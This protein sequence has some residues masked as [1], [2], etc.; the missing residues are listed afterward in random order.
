MTKINNAIRRQHR[1]IAPLIFTFLIWTIISADSVQAQDWGFDPVIKIGGEVDD[2]ALL[3]IRT[4]EELKLEGY[5]VEA[6]VGIDY[7]SPL[8]SFSVTPRVLLRRY[9]DFD[10]SGATADNPD[11][12]DFESTDAFV[13]SLFR[14][15]MRSSSIGFRG[16]YQRQQVRTAERADTDLLIDDPD[17]ISDDDS[18]Q[19]GIEGTRERWRFTPNWAYQFTNKS[20]I[21]ANLD[22]FNIHYEDVFAN[23]LNDWDD[24]RANLSYR[25]ALSDITTAVLTATGRRYETADGLTETIGY[26]LL[27]G[28]DRS[29]SEKTRLRAMV[30]V[31]STEPE[32]GPTIDEKFTNVVGN[33]SLTRN[34]ETIRILAQYRRSVVGSGL[35]NLSLRDALYM[36]FTRQLNER[37]SAGMGVRAYHDEGLSDTSRLDRDYIQLRTVFT[38]HLSK[39]FSLEFDYRYTVL[40]REGLVAGERANSNHVILWFVYQ[41]NRIPE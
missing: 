8:T 20:S 11:N 25:Y 6:S 40:N 17:E 38:W 12:L 27:A 14:H 33:I 1:L 34:L 31:E 37:I 41:P 7:A 13:R 10:G 18:G 29:V 23:L 32:T 22:Y 3:R 16:N 2:N 19:V 24:I 26:G 15:D 30:G 35:G 21:A 9:P 39:A 28:F 5:L 4:D 36:N